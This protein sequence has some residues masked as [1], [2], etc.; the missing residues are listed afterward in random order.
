MS[1]APGHEIAHEMTFDTADPDFVRAPWD[2][3]EQIRALGG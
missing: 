1:A 3:Y 2:R